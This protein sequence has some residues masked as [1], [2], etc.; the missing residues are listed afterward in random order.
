[1]TVE[2]KGAKGGA[3]RL[4]HTTQQQQ[5]TDPHITSQQE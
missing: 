3:K 1:M 5:R 4:D 2:C